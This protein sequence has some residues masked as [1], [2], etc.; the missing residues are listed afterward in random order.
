MH[1]VEDDVAELRRVEKEK[2]EVMLRTDWAEEK[3]KTRRQERR[4]D[5]L[6][7]SQR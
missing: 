3:T 4:C 7:V 1:D 6:Q 2:T 5:P